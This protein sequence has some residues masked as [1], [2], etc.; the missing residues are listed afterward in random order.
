MIGGEHA[1]R[2]ACG[3]ER[4]WEF[5]EHFE[6]WAAFVVGFEGMRRLDGSTTL[7]TLRGDVGILSRE[8]EIQVTVTEWDPPRSAAFSLEGVTERLTGTGSF[9]VAASDPGTGAAGGPA[10]GAPDAAAG[11]GWWSRLRRRLGRW[12]IRRAHGPRRE[13]GAIVARE[14]V[15]S[16]D[17]G[18]EAWL[19][20]RLQVAP[21]GPMAPMLEMLM[22]P[23]LEPAAEDLSLRIRESIE[24]SAA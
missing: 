5:M 1:V 24:G 17:G 19:T 21:G 4:L 2:V 18:A 8:V 6:N 13:G 3:P 22:A 16:D 10:H 20:F 14:P 7:W 11:E 9:E 23:L 12:L 15:A